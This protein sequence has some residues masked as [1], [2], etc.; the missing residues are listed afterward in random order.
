MIGVDQ[1]KSNAKLDLEHSKRE[2][3]IPFFGTQKQS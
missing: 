2:N 1:S 3:K